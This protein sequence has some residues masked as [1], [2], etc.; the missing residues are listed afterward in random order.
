MIDQPFN[1]VSQKI[2]KN[3]KYEDLYSLETVLSY[4]FLILCLN[5]KQ[6]VTKREII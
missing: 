5:F 3:N 4:F 6:K 2:E 1:F